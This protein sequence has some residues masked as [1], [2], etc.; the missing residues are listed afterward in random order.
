MIIN[1]KIYIH[2][3]GKYF[4]CGGQLKIR[5]REI[6]K[7]GNF[8]IDQGG[9]SFYYDDTNFEITYQKEAKLFKVP[10]NRIITESSYKT[11]QK[12]YL[13][14]LNWVQQQKLL[15]CHSQSSDIYVL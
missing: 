13:T 5:N 2:N 8:P 11:T 10:I 15:C 7:L 12:E 14:R 6:V 9:K 3:K 4:E 1:T